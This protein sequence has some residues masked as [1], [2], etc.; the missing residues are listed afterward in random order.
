MAVAWGNFQ[1]QVGA[2]LIPI[3]DKLAVVMTEKVIPAL[4]QAVGWIEDNSEAIEFWGTRVGVA[5]GAI[6]ALA[7]AV[8]GVQIMRAIA[9]T[10]LL[11]F[12]AGLERLE[13]SSPGAAA[14]LRR[15]GRAAAGAGLLIGAALPF[16]DDVKG[17]LEN[18]GMDSEG[19]VRGLGDAELAIRELGTGGSE[20][21]DK[22]V[23]D[24][25]DLNNGLDQSI[26]TLTGVTDSLGGAEQEVQRLSDA[27]AQ[28]VSEGNGA[29]AAEI[30]EEMRTRLIEAGASAEDVDR[31]FRSYSD[32]TASAAANSDKATGALEKTSAAS[33]AAAAGVG[34]GAAAM[35]T[36]AD[37]TSAASDE[38]AAYLEQVQLATD[39]VYA[40]NSAVLGVADSQ[41]AYNEAV[42]EYGPNSAEAQQAAIDLMGSVGELESA[43]LNGELSFDA[44]SAKLDQWVAQGVI[45]AAQAD[46]IRGRV[47]VL[48]GEAE[49][50]AGAYTADLIA[51]D[52]ASSTIQGAMWF[53][54]EFDGTEAVATMTTVQRTIRE[55]WNAPVNNGR[56][57]GLAA[58]GM[59]SE[60][61]TALVGEFGPE[62]VTFGSAGR[63]S[64]AS[65]SRQLMSAGERE[66]ADAVSLLTQTLKAGGQTS[67]P[68]TPSA[69]A[70][71]NDDDLEQWRRRMQ[72]QPV[73]IEVRPI[74]KA[75]QLV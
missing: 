1:E 66:L 59:F 21:F 29:R 19:L 2:L 11:P 33:A 60:G 25:H 34:E 55:I 35:L 45:T 48:R 68:A 53:L 43:A 75:R 24:V 22:V 61:R 69:V 17:F 38:L 12:S 36:L 4:E 46:A 28:Q 63:V 41:T 50:Y 6:V 44:F 62:I 73:E 37:G 31:A 49:S 64:P 32:A 67:A 74:V 65:Q 72:S 47:S 58:G 51:K 52:R 14:G 57:P 3:I 16:M 42:A 54:G 23:A 8:K 26:F 20:A 7:L 71:V 18:D 9:T 39:P 5:V 13:K 56:P 70:S 27:L 40:L 15:V 30:Y 10:A